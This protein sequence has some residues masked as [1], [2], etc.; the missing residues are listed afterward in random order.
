MSKTP[1]QWADYWPTEPMSIVM[2][3]A[4]AQAVEE[5]R[6]KAVAHCVAAGEVQIAQDIRA[7]PNPYQSNKATNAPLKVITKL[8]VVDGFREGFEL[9]AFNE[10][11]GKWFTVGI[12]DKALN[13]PYQS[14]GE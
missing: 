13:A 14:K 9:E 10:I 8:R 4:M 7:L 11:N 12:C 1:E 6:E 5:F 3:K 2:A